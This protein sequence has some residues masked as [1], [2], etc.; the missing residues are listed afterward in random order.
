LDKVPYGLKQA[1]CVWYSH[2]SD[3]LWSLGFS[4]SK[5]DVSLF[6][7]NKGLVKMFLLVYVNGIIIASS[8]SNATTAILR[9]LQANFAL[10]YL[11]PLHYFLGIEVSCTPDGLYLSQQKY[12]GD[13]LQ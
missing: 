12:T 4:P 10:T 3:K 7:Y 2:L 8:L 5:A 6:H 9:A 13:L 11:G 1:P